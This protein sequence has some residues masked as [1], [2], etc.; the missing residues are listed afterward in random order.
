MYLQ[1]RKCAWRNYLEIQ[2][3]QLDPPNQDSQ[4]I[5]ESHPC[6]KNPLFLLGRAVLEVLSDLSLEKVVLDH[7]RF[8][9][10]LLFFH[11][12]LVIP[13]RPYH[14]DF[15]GLRLVQDALLGPERL[16]SPS[17]QVFQQHLAPL[18]VLKEVVYYKN[19]SILTRWTADTSSVRLLL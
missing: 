8:L 12:L 5:Q 17:F 15:P 18:G 14:R 13:V 11:L 1:G 2:R 6:R 19:M 16:A 9:R 7:L 3:S 4:T 10:V